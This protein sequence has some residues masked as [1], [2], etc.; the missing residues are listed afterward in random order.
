MSRMP[1]AVIRLELQT[2]ILSLVKLLLPD[3]RR[4]S[5]YIEAR[6]PARD[7]KRPGSFKVWLNGAAA[8]AWRDYATGEK[9]DVI[10]LICLCKGMDRKEAIGWAKGWL[11][12]AELDQAAIRRGQEKL[13]ARQL[14]A[15]KEQE[16]LEA[17]KRARARELWLSG[18]PTLRGTVAEQY[19]R[20]RGIDIAQIVHPEKGEIRFLESTEWW[21]GAQWDGPRKVK[22]GPH[23]PAIVCAVRDRNG[24]VT[25]CHL[26]F[27]RPDGMAKADVSYPKMMLGQ[28]QGG[29]IRLTRGLLNERLE[30][31]TRP[32]LLGLCEGLEDG[33]S[34]ALAAPEARI[35]A[36]TSLSN[37]RHTYADHEGI[38]GVVVAKDNDWG[39]PQAQAEFDRAIEALELQGKPVAVMQVHHGKD[40]ND[41]LKGQKDENL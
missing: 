13:R 26:T 7:D 6:N 27:L 10:D 38:S 23:F 28:I 19:F 36:A 40:V 31:A 14:Q 15:A 1:I 30:E 37:L 24:A 41:L 25:G 17:K 29:V 11:G 16:A 39:K 9:G 21:R 2:R 34:M 32:M 20:A 35:W 4:V 3:G 5:S 18:K 12:M 22:S 8:G 33:F